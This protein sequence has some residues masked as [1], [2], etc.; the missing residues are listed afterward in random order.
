M[1]TIL[2][3]T[4]L[5][6]PQL[7]AQ[8]VD[9]PHLIQRLN[10][11][12]QRPL[13]LI[14][15]SAGYGK[16]TLISSWLKTINTPS[17]WLSLDEYDDE[18]PV[19]LTYFVAAIQTIF[20]KVFLKTQALVSAPNPPPLSTIKDTL[21][22][23]MREIL[24]PFILVLDDFH[25]IHH[26]DIHDL[27]NDLL[28]YPSPA[29]HL[30]L[31]T[32]R[33][34]PLPITKLR[35]QAKLTEIRSQ[36]L[37]FT[38]TETAVFLQQMD[39]QID[40]T[41][42]A[43]LTQ[44]TEGWITGLRLS[45]LSLRHRGAQLP[46]GQVPQNV[47]YVTD[48]LIVEALAQL[49]PEI[50][51]FL[52]STSI[53]N[54]LC[55][56]LCDA[57]FSDRPNIQDPLP[58]VETGEKNTFADGQAILEWL[59]EQNLFI[60]PLDD[61]HQ[62]YRYHHLFQELLQMQLK[63]SIDSDA[64]ND[65]H[66]QA[67]LWLSQA[68]LIDEAL[69]HSLAAGDVT[70][71]AELVEQNKQAVLED[72]RWSILARWLNQ[73]PD[74][75]I[76]QRP[77]LLL[78][79]AW[80]L[81]FQGAYE[82]IPAIL[83]SLDH[84]LKDVRLAPELEG[85]LDYFNALLLYW[86]WQIEPSLNLFRRAVAHIPRTNLGGRNEAE[87]YLAIASQM[88]GKG[89]E[90]ARGYQ[91]TLRNNTS[92][93]PRKGYLLASL[94]FV[95]LLSGKMMAVYEMAQQMTAFGARTQNDLVGSWGSYLM[96]Y[97]HY[98]WSN[99]ETAVIHFSTALQNRFFLDVNT[100]IDCYAGLIFSYQAMQQPL[101]ALE[102][103]E[104]M[105]EFAQQTQ[106]PLHAVLARSVQTRLYLLQGDLLSASRWLET[107]ELDADKG[108]MFF[109]LEQ[110]RITQCRILIAQESETSLYQATEK[111]NEY[112]SLC[113]ETYNIPRMVEIM[114]LKT[115]VH[116]KR[117]QLDEAQATLE[118]ALNLA[119]PGGT[120]RPFVELGSE[121]IGI[122]KRLQSQG[123]TPD[124]IENIL[125]AFDTVQPKDKDSLVNTLTNR[126]L[127]ILELLAQRLTNK[128]IAERLFIS[129][130]TVKKH[131]SKIYQ[132]LEAKNRRQAVSKAES[133]ALISKSY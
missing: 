81:N 51:A 44:N 21:I 89:E 60:I 108:T 86:D 46:I 67:S 40:E 88:A 90:I 74:E 121:F 33:D 126:E 5:H 110:P 72:G 22:G 27:F 116:C 78:A 129:P 99:L 102:I 107:V 75:I 73:L 52:L 85:D 31:I 53:L 32:R 18:S 10:Q 55:G 109:W 41:A 114:L 29:M 61:H 101:K 65:L 103:A 82:K 71:A 45:A 111:L 124:Y 50:T 117:A 104:Q 11:Y 28:R 63:Q 95:Y 87:I 84:L 115:L 23:E 100:P 14:S 9:R 57:V 132:K 128:E 112:G 1:D 119:Q 79:S 4:K 96:G 125:N 68:G 94:A 42:V 131:T 76:L 98:K 105:L 49:P 34:P 7:S 6:P 130:L 133:L 43:D 123:V 56:S 2:I 64:F 97:V 83:K 17:A 25:V 39:I 38:E 59:Y 77:G 58:N 15:A 3:Q 13:T 24:E 91:K 26:V 37:R 122:F 106:N 36:E 20:P 70:G 62:W 54:R 16:S 127:D 80:V 93:G 113:Q 118:Q 48:Y 19:F 66:R 12:Q 69:R 35:A 92:D 8:T 47:Q 120:I 30:V